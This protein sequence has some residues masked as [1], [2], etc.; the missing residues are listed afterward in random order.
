M[1]SADSDWAPFISIVTQTV[2]S[3][4]ERLRSRLV[5]NSECVEGCVR[6]LRDGYGVRDNTGVGR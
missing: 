1:G 2:R 3:V 4:I 5:D 6:L